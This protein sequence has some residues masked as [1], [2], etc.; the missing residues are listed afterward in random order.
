MYYTAHPDNLIALL[1]ATNPPSPP[2]TPG[3]TQLDWMST[4]EP[5]NCKSKPVWS[6]SGYHAGSGSLNYQFFFFSISLI[7]KESD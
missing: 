1:P 4:L 7:L 6:S 5:P 2:P 3:I